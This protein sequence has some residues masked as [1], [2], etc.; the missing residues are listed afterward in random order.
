MLVTGLAVLLALAIAAA[1]LAL[2]GLRDA[3]AERDAMRA[4]LERLNERLAG[5]ERSAGDAA[6]HAEAAGSLLLEKGL[7]DEEELEAARRR[8]S[9]ADQPAPRGSRTLH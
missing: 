3:A 2:R 9:P 6:S 8:L 1:A 5:A 7:A 4:E